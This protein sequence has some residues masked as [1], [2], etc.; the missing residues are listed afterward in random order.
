MMLVLHR[1]AYKISPNFL[2]NE[3]K[4]ETALTMFPPL[5]EAALS[6]IMSFPVP[7]QNMVI[8][9]MLNTEKTALCS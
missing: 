4:Y 2:K 5:R 9:I 1:C 6:V 3:R 7:G 8:E